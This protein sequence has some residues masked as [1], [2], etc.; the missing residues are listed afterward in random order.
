[1]FTPITRKV[2]TKLQTKSLM[3][4][5]Y[6]PAI[7]GP[8]VAAQIYGHL[9]FVGLFLQESHH[10]H[11]ILPF[12]GGV[13]GFLPGGGSA[14]SFFY[15]REDFSEQS[16]VLVCNEV[17]ALPFCLFLCNLQKIH[18]ESRSLTTGRY[19][20]PCFIRV[21]M[22]PDPTSV[23]HI[24]HA[25]GRSFQNIDLEMYVMRVASVHTQTHTHTHCA[26]R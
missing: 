7:P 5:K 19:A 2:A 18:C 17:F 15:A 20:S 12:R 25:D 22:A 21:P 8:E 24:V 11:K 3:S 4:V 14:N 1:M 16:K 23:A 6:S 10:A 26:R 9:G 13:L